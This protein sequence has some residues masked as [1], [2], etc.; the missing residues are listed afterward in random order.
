MHVLRL[1]LKT[2]EYDKQVIE[3]RF[4]VLSN[5]HNATVKHARKLMGKLNCI[6]YQ[7]W[8]AEYIPLLKKKEKDLSTDEKQRKKFLAD[9]MNAFRKGIGL[10]NYDLQSYASTYGKK[11]NRYVSSQQMQKEGFRIYKGV[12]KVLFD[13]GEELHLK[14]HSDLKTI[15]GKSKGNGAVF[16]R[17]DFSVRWMGLELKCKVPKSEKETS[18]IQASLGDNDISYCE[19]ERLMFPNGWHYYINVYLKGDAPKKL[20]SVGIDS[21]GID[22]GTSTVAGVSENMAVLEE[23]APQSRKYNKRINRLQKRMDISKRNMNPQKYNSDGTINKQNHNRW[24]YSNTYIKNRRKLKSL[25][26]QKSA[27]TKQSHEIMCNRLLEN[28]SH[29]FVEDMN[30]KGLQR[31][32]KKTE[33]QEKPTGIK[34]KDGTTKAVYKYKKKKRFGRSLNNRAPSMFL[35]ILKRKVELYGGS[36][37]TIDTKEFKATQYNH[38]IDG[39]E[40]IPLNQRFKKVGNS[41][42]Q[43]DLYSAFLIR[44]TN[45]DLTHPDRNKCMYNFERFVTIQD[46]LIEDMKRKNISFKQ[47]FGF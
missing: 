14:K 24:V 25:Y 20:D 31:R 1:P 3:H 21:M 16:N 2:T 34:Q 7:E 35:V 12:E 45:K 29:F 15:C 9:K 37:E 36:L 5:I 13:N 19:I 8:L 39:F 6:E 42:V 26:R 41:S 28:S 43:R 10:T 46:K 40:K 17:E 32:A 30:F 22:I 11:F 23:L 33:R 47:C 18:Y 44:N 4:R 38:V 27:Y